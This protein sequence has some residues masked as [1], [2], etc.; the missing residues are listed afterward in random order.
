MSSQSTDARGRDLLTYDVVDSDD[1]RMG[2]VARIW[3]DNVSDRVKFVGCTSG[4]FLPQVRV[5]PAGDVRIDHKDR[6]IHVPYPAREIKSAPSHSS[7][8]SLTTDQ[9][10]KVYSYYD[11][12]QRDHD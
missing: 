1:V 12:S 11:H 10:S 5:I 6:T 7:S 8:V 3:P 2:Q 9:E 4:R